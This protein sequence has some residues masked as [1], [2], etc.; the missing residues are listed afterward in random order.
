MLLEG[1]QEC[2]TRHPSSVCAPLPPDDLRETALNPYS[3]V[4]HLPQWQLRAVAGIVFA[5]QGDYL[6][7][8]KCCA[9]GGNLECMAVCVQVYLRMDRPDQ[10]ERMAATMMQTDEDASISQLCNAWACLALGGAKVMDACYTFQELAERYSW[11]AALYN[12][13]AVAHMKMGQWDEAERELT[14]ALGRAP[15]DPESLANMYVCSQHLGRATS[16]KYLEQLGQSAPGHTL[17]SR[18][19]QAEANFDASAAAFA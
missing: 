10:A 14:E 16:A 8:L 1:I 18:L 7:A 13:C 11:T 2:P 6:E 17:L 3:Y 15:E 19:A 9:Q 4:P 5:D 12:G